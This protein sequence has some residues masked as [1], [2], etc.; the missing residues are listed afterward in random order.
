MESLRLKYRLPLTRKQ[1]DSSADCRHSSSLSDRLKA[2]KTAA[3]RER[4]SYIA[5]STFLGPIWTNQTMYI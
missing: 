4:A 2:V 3:V 5:L 1:R